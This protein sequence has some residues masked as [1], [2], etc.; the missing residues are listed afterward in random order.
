MNT[1]EPMIDNNDPRLTA[2]A[3]GE[4]APADVAQIEAA[5]KSSPELRAVVADIRR[6]SESISN[7]FQTEPSLQLTP[8]QKSQLLAEAKSA[9]NFD[10]R[11]NNRVAAN[12]TP[13]VASEHYQPSSASSAQWIKIAVAAGLASV[14]IGG[15]YYFSQA[16]KA[17]MARNE[18]AASVESKPAAPAG[19]ESN[20]KKLRQLADDFEDLVGSNM[21]DAEAVEELPSMMKKTKEPA[22][23]AD[24]FQEETDE[25]IPF[26]LKSDPSDRILQPPNAIADA[27]K[28]P[29]NRPESFKDTDE[30]VAESN[31]SDGN[32]FRFAPGS[33][34]YGLA[35]AQKALDRSP[36]GSLNLTV[37]PQIRSRGAKSE[38]GGID[39]GAGGSPAPSPE[40]SEL[41]STNRDMAAKKSSEISK[42]AT[43]PPATFVLQISDQDAKQMVELLASNADPLQQRKLSFNDLIGL[44][45]FPR[46]ARSSKLDNSKVSDDDADAFQAPVENRSFFSN[47]TFRAGLPGGQQPLV[48]SALAS[49]LRELVNQPSLAIRGTD[50]LSVPLGD[51]IE[52]AAVPSQFDY[53][54]QGDSPAA[55]TM[56]S[57]PAFAAK[58]KALLD[59]TTIPQEKPN[60]LARNGVRALP[61]RDLI[62]R[63]MNKQRL[64]KE[65]NYDYSQ[66]IEQLK[67]KLEIRNQSVPAAK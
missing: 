7:V 8:E 36:L 60:E 16:D 47:E 23:Q 58:G 66:V 67:L 61:K 51:G 46:L 2:Y 49:K 54:I 9:S 38:F 56:Q 20:E 22:K 34:L 27:S 13:A 18:R 52:G 64:L 42:A 43:N 33:D 65:F 31:L 50:M 28:P 35:T 21:S 3:L 62:N 40:L 59:S 1:Q 53:Q 10:V 11:S 32:S 12:V 29:T 41:D 48:A 24:S 26:D 14:L 6:A 25:A 19:E 17:S 55:S 15:A 4:L 30:P 5:L 63:P 39:G 37:V 57:Q 44:Q 45:A